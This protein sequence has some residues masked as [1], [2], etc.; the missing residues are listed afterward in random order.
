MPRVLRMGGD[1]LVRVLVS[2]RLH[3]VALQKIVGPSGGGLSTTCAVQNRLGLCKLPLLT[4]SDIAAVR[5]FKSSPEAMAEERGPKCVIFFSSRRPSQPHRGHRSRAC[6]AG[7][8]SHGDDRPPVRAEAVPG[9]GA[10]PPHPRAR[11]QCSAVQPLR[12]GRGRGRADQLEAVIHQRVQ[13]CLRARARGRG[14][15]Y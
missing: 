9:H 2:P 8:S 15:R 5:G 3:L 12:A 6:S 14:S 11:A 13:A 4:P 7:G 1:L 10:A